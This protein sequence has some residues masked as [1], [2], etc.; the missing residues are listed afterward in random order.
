MV[1]LV[2]LS[3]EV[4]LQSTLIPLKMVLNVLANITYPQVVSGLTDS[5]LNAVVNRFKP[6]LSS[7]SVEDCRLRQAVS[8][9]NVEDFRMVDKFKSRLRPRGVQLVSQRLPKVPSI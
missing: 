2:V 8:C 9:L 4:H 5:R 3:M 1:V 6:V 7:H